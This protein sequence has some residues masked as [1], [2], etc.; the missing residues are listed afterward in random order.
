MKDNSST[1]TY[2]ETL[3]RFGLSVKPI[4]DYKDGCSLSFSIDSGKMFCELKKTTKTEKVS[5]KTFEVMNREHL[6]KLLNAKTL[7][8]V[9]LLEI[10]A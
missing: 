5:L 8:E 1:P 10:V 2:S 7:S 6:D 9:Q 4:R 3:K